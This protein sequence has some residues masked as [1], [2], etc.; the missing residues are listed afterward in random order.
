META[1]A[2]LDGFQSY[3]RIIISILMEISRAIIH[4]QYRLQLNVLVP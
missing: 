4:I 2:L 1:A 3:T